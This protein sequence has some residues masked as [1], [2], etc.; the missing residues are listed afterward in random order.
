[1]VD[2]QAGTQSDN[3]YIMLPQHAMLYSKL[4]QGATKQETNKPR[5]PSLSLIIL[6]CIMFHRIALSAMTN[7]LLCVGGGLRSSGG[8][9]ASAGN[10]LHL[11][12][13]QAAHLQGL[14]HI[15]S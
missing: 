5:K 1:M 3:C 2:M 11:C 12:C 8:A 10:L 9:A 14:F 13:W 6:L 15:L 4:S 7:V